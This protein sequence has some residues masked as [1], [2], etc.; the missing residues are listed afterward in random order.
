[1]AQSAFFISVVVC[2]VVTALCAKTRVLSI[3]QHGIMGNTWLLKALVAEL[4]I[5][6]LL[7]FAPPLNVVFG[8]A[9]VRAWHL[10][11]GLPWALIIFAYDEG[12]KLLLRRLGPGSGFY[13]AMHY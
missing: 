3:F 9:P 12:R 5:T 13:R 10:A 11:L 2:K 7:V 8:T 1:M 6:A 4:G